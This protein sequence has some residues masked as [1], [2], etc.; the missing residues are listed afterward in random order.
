MVKGSEGSGSIGRL[1]SGNRG[2]E[3][4]GKVGKSQG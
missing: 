2:G 4:N 1:A 3:E